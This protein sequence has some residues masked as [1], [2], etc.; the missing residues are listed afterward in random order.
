ML[1]SIAITLVFIPTRVGSFLLVHILNIFISFLGDWQG[2]RLEHQ[3]ITLE[4]MAMF[5]FFLF[6]V[7]CFFRLVDI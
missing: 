4:N 5:G 1:F 3:T 6:F 7:F 2:A